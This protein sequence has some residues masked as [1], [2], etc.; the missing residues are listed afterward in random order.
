MNDVLGV[1]ERVNTKLT[2]LLFGQCKESLSINVL[3]GK[4]V[5]ILGISDMF[6]PPGNL[7]LTP[8]VGIWR[9]TVAADV[10]FVRLVTVFTVRVSG[11]RFG[12]LIRFFL[13]FQ[14]GGRHLLG[15]SI[16][17]L[18]CI[19][20]CNLSSIWQQAINQKL[21]Q[22]WFAKHGQMDSNN[23]SDV[24]MI[25]IGDITSFRRLFFV[26]QNFMLQ[27]KPRCNGS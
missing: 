21:N 27:A 20:L 5:H 18:C 14:I 22:N 15:S 26:P 17:I 19:F 8:F 11:R 2:K 6:D 1:A 3:L 24:I 16:A 13:V 9:E 23:V 7:L 12:I 4:V 10:V 25:G